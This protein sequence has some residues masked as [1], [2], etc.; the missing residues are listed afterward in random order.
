MVVGSEI[1]GAPQGLV[2]E[3]LVYI[4][5]RRNAER[6]PLSI[7]LRILT[8][9]LFLAA[10]VLV[11]DATGAESNSA[12]S[13]AQSQRRDPVPLV[14]VI[15][16]DQ[17]RADLPLQIPDVASSSGFGRFLSHGV[18]YK[19]AQYEHPFTLTAA[20]HATVFTGAH[21][22]RHGIVGNRWYSHSERRVVDAVADA[23]YRTFGADTGSSP[24]QLRTTT[25]GD[26]LILASAGQSKVIAVSGKARSAVLPGGRLGKAFWYEP[27]AKGFTTSTYYYASPP[28]WLADRNRQILQQV[29]SI[30][31]PLQPEVSNAKAAKG[32]VPPLPESLGR[33]FPHHLGSPGSSLFFE[34]VGNS[35]FLDEITLQFAEAL[36]ETE[37]LGSDRYPDLLAISLSATDWIGHTFGPDSPEALDNLIRLDRALG[38]FFAALDAR[39]GRDRYLVVLTAD[40][41][42]A[43]AP[44]YRARFGLTAYRLGLHDIVKRVNEQLRSH[45]AI[46]ENLIEAATSPFIYLNLAALETHRL[47]RR[48]VASRVA[49][50]IAREPGIARV[51]PTDSNEL[52]SADPFMALLRRGIDAERSGELIVVQEPSIFL[53]DDAKVHAATHGSPYRY[54]RHVPIMIF[55]A[56]LKAC[57]VARRV[58]PTAIAPTLAAYLQIPMPPLAE[59]ELLPEV[60]GTRGG[61]CCVCAL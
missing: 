51:I 60:I 37:K 19:D 29:P 31:T 27:K 44:E 38:K 23:E 8:F 35:P 36:I 28:K 45:Y 11:A 40:H 22:S 52:A 49:S 47:E 13:S 1:M 26:E 7:S 46:Q 56:D 61:S 12:S 34:N 42:A 32:K 39:L 33:D 9:V 2:E 17:L 54:D 48:E 58:A 41:G 25:F 24:R 3:E 30:W 21:P 14:V 43:S 20:G 16:V 57:E 59:G 15:V 50:L 18:V 53:L 10:H 55:G 6:Q 4:R 5:S